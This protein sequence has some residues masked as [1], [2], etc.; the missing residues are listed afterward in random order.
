MKPSFSIR[1]CGLPLLMLAA[2]VAAAPAPAQIPLGGHIRGLVTDDSGGPIAGARVVAGYGRPEMPPIPPMPPDSGLVA[3]RTDRAGRYDLDVPYPGCYLVHAGAAGYLGLFYP[4]VPD[5]WQATCIDVDGGRV[6]DGIDFRLGP[7]GAIAGRVTDARSGEP[8]AGAMVQ[9]WPAF[10]DSTLIPPG[11]PPM[12]EPGQGGDPSAPPHGGDPGYP[13]HWG[14]FARTGPDGTYRIE[15]LVAGDYFVRG[16]ADGHIGEFYDDAQN[17]EE[18]TPVAVLPPDATPGIDLA[19]G[20][21]G[22]I[23][24][25]VVAADTREPIAG[26]L[27]TIGG[28]WPVPPEPLP[29][30]GEPGDPPMGDPDGGGES[31]GGSNGGVVYPEPGYPD[32]GVAVTARDGTYRICGL[33]PGDYLVH[34]WA[35]GYLGEFYLDARCPDEADPVA[36]PA[37]GEVAGIDF[38]LGRGGAIAGTVTAD[39]LP[40]PGAWV[41]AYPVRGDSTAVPDPPYPMCGVMHGGDAMADSTGY[42]VLSGLPT[43]EYFVIAE[44]PGYLPTFFGG[45]QD[46]RTAT[47]VAVVAPETAIGIDIALERGGAIAGVVRDQETGAPVVR[48]WVEVYLPGMGYPCYPD[49]PG[50]NPDGSTGDP[51]DPTYPDGQ[52][53]GPM[54]GPLGAPTDENGAYLIEG[55]PGGEH[56]VY[57]SAWEQGY[58]PEFYRDA[59]SPEA[60]TPIVVVAPETTTGIDFTLA[61]MAPLDGA[62]GGRVVAAESGDPIGGAVIVAMSLA[63]QAGF[64]VADSTGFYLIPSLAAGDYYVLAAAPGRVGEFYDGA[65]SWEEATPVAVSG[66]VRGIDFALDLLGSGPGILSGRV[67][68]GDGA[69]IA[70]AWV[71]AEPEAGGAPGFTTTGADGR[72]VIGGLEP[73]IYHV[74]ATRPGM[75]D[76]YHSHGTPGGPGEPIEVSASPLSG[77]D[78]VMASGA[79]PAGLLRLEPAIPNPFRDET[80]IRVAVAGV[81]GALRI[82]LID[83]SG[84]V[85]RRFEVESA[86]AGTLSV[87]W[88]GRDGSG[89]LAPSG[90]YICRVEAD[91]QVST[92]R[93]V[94]VR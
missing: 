11:D 80:A 75:G 72:Y 58:E 83:V 66:P 39:G 16:E 18:A 8:I 45:G 64:G 40:Q 14:G 87:L 47:P 94:L 92:G 74:R 7:A 38:T 82:D 35:D 12:G 25:R 41:W 56:I 93:L 4:G 91:G 88:D 30:P 55:V 37:D 77:I 50:S 76:A 20:R 73:G 65:M 31:G 86:A 68:D 51:D 42:Y 44:A 5:P 6:I 59:R 34:A 1:Q 54:R 21:G 70:Q 10:R 48:A 49:Y 81:T 13:E 62:I 46:P 63:G 57:A 36:V 9:A 3:T 29:P 26:A 2:L 79:P 23:L 53:G 28:M 15:G 71:Y 89:R 19:L 33:P 78:I 27:V 52:P 61:R 60:A 24:G 43:G 85:V 32:R 84:R 90:V 22:C 17:V 69:G 67:V